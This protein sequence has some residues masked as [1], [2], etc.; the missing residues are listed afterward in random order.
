MSK[1][2]KTGGM[3]FFNKKSVDPDVCHDMTFPFQ[4]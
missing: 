2:V 3:G 1:S 4:F